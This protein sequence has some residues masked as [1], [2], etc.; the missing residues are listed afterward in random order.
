VTPLLALG[1]AD[2][3]NDLAKEINGECMGEGVRVEGGLREEEWQ[4][5]RSGDRLS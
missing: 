1:Y 5:S 3:G 2:V 4:G